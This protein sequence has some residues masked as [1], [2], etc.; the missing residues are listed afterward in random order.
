MLCHKGTK[1]RSFLLFDLSYVEIRLRKLSGLK[2]ADK[3]KLKV[4]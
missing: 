2:K 4:I 1:A 3:L